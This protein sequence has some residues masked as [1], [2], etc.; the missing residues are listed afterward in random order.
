[1]PSPG[2]PNVSATTTRQ[3]ETAFLERVIVRHPNDAFV[4][5]ATIESQWER[6]T[7]RSPP[8]FARAVKEYELFIDALAS[9]GA[10]VIY[11]GSG[12]GL[13]MDSLYARDASIIC[14]RGAILCRM[15]KQARMAEPENLGQVYERLGIPV[16]GAIQGDGRLEGGDFVWLGPRLAAVGE[17]Y[18]TNPQG[19]AQLREFLGDSVDE[20]ITVPLP[21]F[22]GPGDVFHLMS[23]ISPLDDDLALVYSP[24]MPVRFRQALLERG[25]GLVEVPAGE[26][27]DI[28]GNVL[29]IAPR[30]VLMVGG[31]PETTGRLA[32]AGVEVLKFSAFEIST[33]GDG[34]P[35]C[36][37]RPLERRRPG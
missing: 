12:D 36:L 35:T 28:A 27:D 2:E 25:I 23:L 34:G 8:D 5:Q 19:I 29:A 15:G 1:M 17:G 18:R 4:D 30:K 13:S 3:S 11:A 32:A 9:Q 10:E 16:I 33:K 31:C 14:D 7:Y 37:T 21:H 26:F 6:L 22:R 20:L 24:L